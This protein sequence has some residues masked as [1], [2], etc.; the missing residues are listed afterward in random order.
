[1]PHTGTPP[2]F[3]LAWRRTVFGTCLFVS[4]VVLFTPAPDVPS[5]PRGLDKVIHLLLFAAL[6][7]S[8]RYAGIGWRVLVPALVTYAAASEPLQSLP[9]IG[10]ATSLA[11]W[12]ADVAGV[13]LAYAG[14]L[15][16][17]RLRSA[18]MSR[19]GSG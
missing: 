19:S 6:T 16:R 17:T 10:R 12:L 18:S 9:P 13:L 5:G 2:S 4:F 8:G 3:A 7:A 14:T 15:A 11:D 1:M